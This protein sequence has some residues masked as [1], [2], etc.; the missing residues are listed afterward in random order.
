MRLKRPQQQLNR[1]V[2]SQTSGRL[3]PGTTRKP[4]FRRRRGFKAVRAAQL[5]RR[6]RRWLK[7]ATN[8]ASRGRGRRT[9]AVSMDT[10]DVRS[11]ESD[12]AAESHRDRQRQTRV[13]SRRSS[14]TS[15]D[16]SVMLPTGRPRTMRLLSISNLPFD[17]GV[18]ELPVEKKRGWPKGRPRLPRLNVEELA[19]SEPLTSDSKPHNGISK[20]P[21]KRKR[22][23]PPLS[24]KK[25]NSEVLECEMDADMDSGSKGSNSDEPVKKKRGW[26]KGRPRL[27]LKDS[28]ALPTKIAS[29]VDVNRRMRRSPLKNRRFRSRI[30]RPRNS[31]KDDVEEM[32]AEQDQCPAPKAD[33]RRCFSRRPVKRRRR[34]WPKGRR[35]WRKICASSSKV[36]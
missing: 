33:K 20:F 35:H 15:T 12:V 4:T 22:G 1:R 19:K 24:L 16:N 10:D 5:M 25:E 11:T 13:S 17:A 2:G 31:P 27:Y 28:E 26:P 29:N 32:K 36:M 8:G 30:G 18:S 3:S 9:S 34:G 14:V 6:K 23:R 7:S 21:A